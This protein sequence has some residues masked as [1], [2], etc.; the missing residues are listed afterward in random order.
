MAKYIVANAKE[1]YHE[2]NYKLKLMSMETIK[3]T[4]G[5]YFKSI[6]IVH[7]ALVIGI[8]FFT[9]ISVFLQI[10]GFGTVGQEINN[11]LL[12]LVP[13]FALIGIFAS[14]LVFRKKLKGIREKSNL[15]EKMEDY[16]SAL[17]IKLALIEGPSFFT[18]VAYLLTGNYI[19][20]GIVVVLIIVFLISSGL[21]C[22]WL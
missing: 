16:R 12:L 9:L 11:G 22:P 21:D 7:I 5:G 18:V 4:S 8:V 6:K 19:F 20:L 10:S 17:I 3:M 13:I 1:Y 15:K 2:P 14:N